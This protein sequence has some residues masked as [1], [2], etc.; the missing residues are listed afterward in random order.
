ME[1][2]REQLYEMLWSNGVGKTE[3]ALGLKQPELKKLCEDFQI[4]KP[5][6]NYWIALSLGKSPEKTPLP[7]MEDSQIIHTEDYIKPKRIKREKP[8]LKPEPPKKTPDGKYEPRELPAEEPVTIYSVPDKLIVMDPILMDTKQKLCERNNDGNNP[9]K[10]KNPY[11]SSPKKWLDINVYQEQEDRALRIFS[12]IWR[13]AE[14][15]GYHLKIEVRKGTYSNVCTTYFV[16]RGHEIRVELK[17]INKRVKEDEHSWTKLVSSGRLKFV[18]D[19]GDHC[20][21]LNQERVAAQDTEHTHLEDKIERIIEILGEI[22][23]ERDQAE[24]ERKQAEER[25]KKEEELRRQE[26]ERKRLEAEEQA[27][28]EARR[29]E[30]RRLVTDLLLEAERTRTAAMIREYANQ[31]EIVMAG[32]MDAE[33]LQTKL[34]WMRQ[35]ADYIDPFINCEDEWL[36]PADIRK[37][38]SPEIIKTTEELRPSYGYGKETT[39]SYWQIKNMWWWR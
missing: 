31:Y 10:K 5:S 20:Y 19:R 17:E 39:Y 16:V 33:Q 8:V 13:A 12:T 36:Q 24:V 4:T 37:L 28:I 2:T 23:D 35:K 26:K 22:A 25:R 32:R 29:E 7:P 15:K 3:K 9:W 18:C 6:S 30:E 34:Q 11:K 14:A 38:L 21:R 27:R 1:L